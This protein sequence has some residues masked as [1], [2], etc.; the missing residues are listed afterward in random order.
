M[1]WVY[2][3]CIQNDKRGQKQTN[4]VTFGKMLRNYSEN[5]KSEEKEEYPALSQDN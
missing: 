3:L 4:S 5:W 1:H 2:N